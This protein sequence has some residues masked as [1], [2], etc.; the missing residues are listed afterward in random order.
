[1]KFEE[2]MDYSDMNNDLKLLKMISSQEMSS[3][4]GSLM[5]SSLEV[6]S[7]R[8]SLEKA[9]SFMMTSLEVGSLMMS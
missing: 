8:M 3:Q 1:M 2:A 5:T 4:G 9:S 6:S 7:F